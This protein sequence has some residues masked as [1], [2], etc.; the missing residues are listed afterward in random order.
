MFGSSRVAFEAID[1]PGFI[2]HPEKSIFQ[3]SKSLIFLGYRLDSETMT[4]SPTDK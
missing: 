2:V 4:V 1:V 3:P